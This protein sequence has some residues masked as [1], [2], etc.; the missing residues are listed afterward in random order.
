MLVRVEGR[1]TLVNPLQPLKVDVGM[2]VTLDGIVT[3]D[4]EVQLPNTLVPRAVKLNGI[5]TLVSAVQVPN[6]ELPM[7]V[8]PSGKRLLVT[9]YY[10]DSVSL[11]DLKT[12]RVIAEQDLRPGK[13]DPR[14][15]G[16]PGGEFPV[17][18]VWQSDDIAYLSAPRDREI[19]R[20]KVSDKAIAV[21]SRART[22]GEPTSL[23]LDAKAGRLYAVEDNDDRLAMLDTRTGALVAEPRLGLPATLGDGARGLVPGVLGAAARARPRCGAAAA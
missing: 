9:N 1:E 21:D 22:V 8:S 20:L 2:L 14:Q 11:I 13:I 18:V 17:A 3:V 19:I 15:S 4:S 16:V 23:L 5:V 6:T 12:R 7:V 10:N